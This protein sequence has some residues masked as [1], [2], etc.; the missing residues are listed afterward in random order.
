MNTKTCTKCK[1]EKPFE[2]FSKSKGGKF[3]LKSECK[4]CSSV[5]FKKFYEENRELMIQKTNTF[6]ENNP[7]Y[8]KNNYKRYYSENRLALIRKSL[9]ASKSLTPE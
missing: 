8:S 1:L 4:E 9:V 7:D 2:F 6:R 3:G 5:R